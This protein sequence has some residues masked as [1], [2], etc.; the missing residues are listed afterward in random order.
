VN[1]NHLPN[2]L[3]IGAAKSGTTSLWHYLRQHPQI[4]LSPRKEPRFFVFEGETVAYRGPGDISWTEESVTTLEAYRALFDPSPDQTALGEASNVYLYFARKAAPRIARLI[5]QARLIAIL[6][7][8]VDRAYSNY[9]ML[10][11]EGRESHTDFRRAL[12]EEGKRLREGWSPGWAYTGRG[13]YADSISVFREHFP[14]GQMLFF[15]YEDLRDSPQRT[16]GAIFDFLGIR[17]FTPDMSRRYN[18]SSVPRWRW[19]AYALRH[20]TPLS[21][22]LRLFIPE[23]ARNAINARLRDAVAV[24]PPKMSGEDRR[25]LRDMFAEDIAKTSALIGRDLSHWLKA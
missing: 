4:C 12:Q 11:G 2:F 23:P 16:L 22:T 7:N 18:V 19:L 10:R 14:G 3:I 5:P 24:R 15:L 21:R 13:F 8:P 9:L 25:F 1:N 20:R 17:R 6:R